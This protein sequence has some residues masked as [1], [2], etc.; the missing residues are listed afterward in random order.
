MEDLRSQLQAWR[1]RRLWLLGVGNPGQGDD[2]FG[3]RLV[4]ELRVA[5]GDRDASL[6]L[7]NVGTCPERYVGLAAQGGCQELVFADAVDFGGAPG[8]LLLVP[9]AELSARR[10]GTSTH[11]VPLTVLAEYAEGLGL[12]A[13][14]LGVQPASLREGD[15][16]SPAVA[17]TLEA[18]VGLLGTVLGDRDDGDRTS[19]T[20]RA[21]ARSRA[22]GAEVDP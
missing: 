8:A 21:R 9:T 4:E 5:L 20:F 2:G 19:I 18:V 16:L 12:R 11:R 7:E 13:W 15:P 22:G 3:V 6:R 17:G 14:I 1:G 10:I